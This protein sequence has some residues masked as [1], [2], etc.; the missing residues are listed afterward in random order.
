MATGCLWRCV[1]TWCG[2]EQ[3]WFMIN[4]GSARHV[5]CRLL[6]PAFKLMPPFSNSTLGWTTFTLPTRVTAQSETFSK[7]EYSCHP[8]PFLCCLYLS[9]V[10]LCWKR[11]VGC[12][13]ITG[14]TWRSCIPLLSAQRGSHPLSFENK[15]K[16][17]NM[18]CLRITG[19]FL[20]VCL[21]PTVSKCH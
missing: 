9:V 5:R 7:K 8:I 21:A 14:R 20:T 19:I 1:A 18:M 6:T 2:L 15:K 12:S 3:M 13:V 17:D 4:V 11:A 10:V 16:K